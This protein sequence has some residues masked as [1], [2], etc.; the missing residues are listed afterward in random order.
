VQ[1]QSE[2]DGVNGTPTIKLNGKVV[3]LTG[4]TQASLAAQVKAATK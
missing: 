3:D 4:L 1:T 2:K